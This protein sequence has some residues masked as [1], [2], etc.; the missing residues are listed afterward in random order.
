MLNRIAPE[1]IDTLP[2]NIQM[3]PN[4]KQAPSRLITVLGLI[5]LFTTLTLM[6]SALEFSGIDAEDD[7]GLKRVENRL[8]FVLTTLSSVGYGDIYPVSRR[9]RMTAGAMMLVMLS[10]LI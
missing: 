8:Y 4:D 2:R 7:S 5:T 6:Y 3:P 10:S 9:A 1:K